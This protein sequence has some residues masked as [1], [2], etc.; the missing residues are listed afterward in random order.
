MVNRHFLRILLLSHARDFGKQNTLLNHTHTS[1]S[2]AEIFFFS[3]EKLWCAVYNLQ[4]G[5]ES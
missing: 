5:C 1:S 4:E 3:K 2:T